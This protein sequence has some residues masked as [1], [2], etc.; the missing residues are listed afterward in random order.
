VP[1]T[2]C[3]HRYQA[4]GYRPGA[5]L[6]HLVEIRDGCCTFPCCSHPATRSDFEHAVPYHQGGQTCACNAGARSR[7]CHRVKQT[8]GWEV[9]QP[10]PGW[11]QWRTPTGRT[12]TQG[13]KEYPN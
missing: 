2:G 10:L 1:V 8:P 11:H 3:D 12:Y 4:P 6:R 7:R 13:P 9:T 5:F